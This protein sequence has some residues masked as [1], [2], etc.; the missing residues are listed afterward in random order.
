MF[1][2]VSTLLL[3]KHETQNLIMIYEFEQF[4]IWDLNQ[5]ITSYLFNF[6]TKAHALV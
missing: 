3:E 1:I 4:L 5:T 2:I 6:D